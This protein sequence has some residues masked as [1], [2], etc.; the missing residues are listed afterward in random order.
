MRTRFYS[1]FS[2]LAVLCSCLGAPLGA[3]GI[4]VTGSAGAGWQS[5][6]ASTDRN[7]SPGVYWNYDPASASDQDLAHYLTGTG[8][9]FGLLRY[10]SPQLSSGAP[11]WGNPASTAGPMASA[12]LNFSFTAA[13]E[14]LYVVNRYHEIGGHA[15]VGYYELATPT[16]LHKLF[17]WADTPFQIG[18]NSINSAAVKSFSPSGPFGF[19]IAPQLNVTNR[20]SQ[21]AMY[22]SQS[23]LNQMEST[24][25]GNDFTSAYSGIQH[26]AVFGTATDLW[27]GLEDQNTPDQADFQDFVLSISTQF[28]SDPTQT[29]VNFLTDQ[30]TAPAPPYNDNVTSKDMAGLAVSAAFTDG[31]ERTGTWG[32][33]GGGVFGVDVN[34]YFRLWMSAVENTFNGTWHLLNESSMG[35][36]TLRLNG[37]LGGVVFDCSWLDDVQ[38]CGLSGESSDPTKWGTVGSLAGGTFKRLGG[39][40]PGELNVEYSHQIAGGGAVGDVYEQ[41][42]IE[43]RDVNGLLP[44]QTLD[45]QADTDAIVPE[46]GSF[47][48]VATGLILVGGLA[49]R[50]R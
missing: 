21:A 49:R 7:L 40:G 26:L 29:V 12:D 42:Q 33:L 43:F 5:F 4:T 38:A 50:K 10:G 20:T 3:Q 48:L 32:D 27:L 8:S 1:S 2:C 23:S 31:I 19:Y 39:Y 11:W 17:T 34:G 37:L 35:L 41:L 28:P 47:M 15:E 24:I 46:P 13:S 36:S 44:N 14:S 6:P 45:F 9:L 30:V 22:F 18:N 25:G 16:V